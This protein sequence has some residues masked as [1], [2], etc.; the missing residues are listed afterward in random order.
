MSDYVAWLNSMCAPGEIRA[1]IF[2]ESP[3]VHPAVCMTRRALEKAGGYVPGPWPEDYSLWLRIAEAGFGLA[4]IPEVLLQWRDLPQ[5]LTRH[6]PEYAAEAILSLKARMLPRIHPRARNGVQVW[7]AGQAGRR[8]SRCLREEGVE[9]LRFFDID[10]RKIGTHLHA[11][12]VL[13]STD[14]E[15]F[16]K[17]L[18]LV[19]VGVRKAKPLIRAYLDPLGFSEGEDYIFVA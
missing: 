18:L 17:D 12:P 2:I 19:A 4:K 16:R 15:R 5:R 3:L 11:C 1:S 13:P 6:N 7:G 9:T 14:V 8:F 10:P